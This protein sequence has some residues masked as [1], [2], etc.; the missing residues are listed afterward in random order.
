MCISMVPFQKW[1][2][3][4]TKTT[5]YNNNNNKIQQKQ[6]QKRKRWVISCDLN[7]AGRCSSP[8]TVRKFIPYC[9]SCTRKTVSTIANPGFWN[10]ESSGVLRWTHALTARFVKFR[11]WIK[12]LLTKYQIFTKLPQISHIHK[13]DIF[14]V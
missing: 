11:T 7:E 6:N 10:T 1:S 4:L 13:S 14:Q 2:K 5:K 12:Q 8:D 9:W 3:R